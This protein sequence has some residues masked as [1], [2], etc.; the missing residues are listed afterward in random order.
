MATAVVKW[1]W[2]LHEHPK[3]QYPEWYNNPSGS[4]YNE[5]WDHLASE[6]EIIY[7]SENYSFPV[8]PKV[9]SNFIDD[10]LKNLYIY[11]NF[12]FKIY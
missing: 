8:D 9:R 2:A 10:F 1:G 3:T 7:F 5:F 4:G 12:I 6:I 11:I